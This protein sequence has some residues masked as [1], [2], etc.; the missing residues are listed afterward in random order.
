MLKILNGI[1]VIEQGT[2]ITGP[3]SAM[4]LADLG[5][6]VIK[7]ESPGEGDPYRNFRGGLYSAHFQAYN[8]NKRSL[9]IDMKSESDKAMFY[10]LAQTADVY[11]QNFRPGAADRMGA[12]HDVLTRINPRLVYCSIS[13]FGPTCASP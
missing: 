5:A 8:R 6:D 11:I 7:L 10:D 3:C 12:G 13:G 4:M 2:F 9:S 1:R